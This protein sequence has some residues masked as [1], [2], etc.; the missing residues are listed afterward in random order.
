MSDHLVEEEVI[1]GLYW[2]P[3]G[4]DLVELTGSITAAVYAATSWAEYRLGKCVDPRRVERKKPGQPGA[5]RRF[6]FS[7]R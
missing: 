4:D 3:A 5:R 6:Q 1:R 2:P 7:K